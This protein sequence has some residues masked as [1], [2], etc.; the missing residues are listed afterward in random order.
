MNGITAALELRSSNR[1]F[2]KAGSC[3]DYEHYRR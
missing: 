1:L 3:L 2:A